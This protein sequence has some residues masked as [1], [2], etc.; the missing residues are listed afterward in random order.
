[1]K[2]ICYVMLVLIERV[3]NIDF[4]PSRT[5]P[6][7]RKVTY[8]NAKLFMIANIG[9]DIMVCVKENGVITHTKEMRFSVKLTKLITRMACKMQI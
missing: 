5:W 1:M 9:V 3:R 7:F 6:K 8:T 2:Y 4:K